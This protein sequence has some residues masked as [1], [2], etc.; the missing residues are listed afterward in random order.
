M[1]EMWVGIISLF[2]EMFRAISEYGIT[3]RAIEQDILKLDYWNPRDFT[4]DKHRTVDDKPYG[5]GPGMLM[6]VQ[7]LRDA[8]NSARALAGESCKVVYLSPQG[9]RLNQEML[10]EMSASEKLILI[11][12]RYEGIDERLIERHVDLEISIGDYVLSGGEL[13]A[14]VLIDGMARLLPGAVGDPESVVRESFVDGMLDYPQYTRPEEVDG[15]K[16]PAVL[17]S[18]D[19]EK[20]RRWRAK[21]SIGRTF[22]RK[23]ELL[24]NRDLGEEDKQLLDEYLKDIQ[25]QI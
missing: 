3:R 22:E 18:G 15:A 17:L 19:H 21:Q 2:P 4:S 24:K 1:Q 16:V 11:A 23:P 7:P 25:K 6:K 10:L 14:M 20:I 12:G 9:E 8:I 5:G 13:A